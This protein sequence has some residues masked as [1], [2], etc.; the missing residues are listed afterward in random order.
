MKAYKATYNCTCKNI[1]FE[2]GKTYTYDKELIMCQQGFHFCK[3]P[4][5]TI[6]YYPPN[7]NFILMEIEVLGD[8]IDGIDIEYVEDKLDKSVTNKFKVTK[9]LSNK[10]S[11]DL[12][13]YQLT[14]DQNNNLINYKNNESYECWKEYDKNNNLIHHKDNT[15]L[16][17]WQEFDQN[18]NI[19]HY[20]NTDGLECWYKYDN[21]NNL[22]H[23]NNNQGY[24]LSL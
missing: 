5:N 11:L 20:K 10:E 15:G 12:I 16:E 24:E 19:I 7:K 22:I 21:N 23:Y 1:T 14:Y 2:L 8:I 6:N 13:G 4:L 9:I 18:N 17:Y 3:N